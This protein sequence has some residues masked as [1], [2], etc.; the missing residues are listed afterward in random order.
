MYGQIC[1]A[2]GSQLICSGMG[3]GLHTEIIGSFC[4]TNSDCYSYCCAAAVGRC[5]SSF[6]SAQCRAQSSARLD[7]LSSAMKA[8]AAVFSVIFVIFMLCV[9]FRKR[10]NLPC[11]KRERRPKKSEQAITVNIVPPEGCVV[12]KIGIP[13]PEFTS[14]ASTG[15]SSDEQRMC[16]VCTF[17]ASS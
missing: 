16:G 1:Q 12:V 7:N 4:A 5:I 15:T 3:L 9:C 11:F 6:D 10:V 2:I 14:R 13:P 8:C 17:S